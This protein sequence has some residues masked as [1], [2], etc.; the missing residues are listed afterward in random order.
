MKK[1]TTCTALLGSLLL[2]S[3]GVNYI[4]IGTAGGRLTKQTE[5][6]QHVGSTPQQISAAECTLDAKHCSLAIR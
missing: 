4:F 3:A 6:V 5:Q 1:F 2:L